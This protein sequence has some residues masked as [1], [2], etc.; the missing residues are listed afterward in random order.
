M[1]IIASDFDGT[2][3]HQGKIS[4]EDK[5]A[6]KKFREAGNKFGIVTGRDFEQAI[7]IKAENGF[8]YDFVICCTGA[9]IRDSQGKIL[10]VKKGKI[11]TFFEDLI[12]KAISF[13]A[14][15]FMISD[16]LLRSY[17]DTT[18]NI[19]NSYNS[20]NEFTHAN[21]WFYKTEGAIKFAQ[22]VTENYADKIS[23]HRNGG[24]VDMPPRD[25]SKVSGIY[26]YAKSF[27][28]PKIYTVGDNVNDI[29]MLREFESFA[30]E[31]ALDEVKSVA[32]H[33]CK[34]V[35]DMIEYIM[36]EK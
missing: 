24:S 10:Y 12:E 29:P 5:L 28:N 2:I 27:E 23:A 16:M 14:G 4:E 35:A 25:T 21:T 17:A 22:Y 33:Q 31:N 13:G 32:K 8:D 26:Q 30:V 7:W 18:K 1:I 20:L 19:P 9:V 34:R 15:S 36:E 3:N 11:D 6:I